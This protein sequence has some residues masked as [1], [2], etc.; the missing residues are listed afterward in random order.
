MSRPSSLGLLAGLCLLIAPSLCCHAQYLSPTFAQGDQ[1]ATP[2]PQPFSTVPLGEGELPAGP[3]CPALFETARPLS[4]WYAD[5][6]IAVL[7][8][9]AVHLNG[10]VFSVKD[11]NAVYLAPRAF[12]GCRLDGGSSVR[13]TYR[14][15]TEVGHLGRQ[16]VWLTD[17]RT[18][19]TFT[20]NWFDIDYV[21]REYAPLEWWRVQWEAG[22][23]FVFRYEATSYEDPYQRQTFS[24]TYFGG[25]PHLGLMSHCLLGRSGWALFGRAD[26]AATFGGGHSSFRLRAL[27][28][29]PGGFVSPPSSDSV[30]TEEFQIDVNLQLGLMKR[31]QLENCAIGLGFGVQ[32][33]VLSRGDL[34][35][36]D[37]NTFGLVNTGLFLRCEVEF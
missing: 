9:S 21:S 7:F 11:H 27:Q 6:E 26:A 32:T 1:L 29:D 20:T 36:C 4:P 37:F 24:H 2:A 14:N 5:A 17:W 16:E 22:G 28:A 12:L 8:N 19:T 23:R 3:A 30:S 25:G 33:D 35:D 15:L 10:Q 13:F 31:W 18:E 34:R